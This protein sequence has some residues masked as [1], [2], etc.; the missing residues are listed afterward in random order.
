M[1]LTS[2]ATAGTSSGRLMDE[3]ANKQ[4]VLGTVS[5]GKHRMNHK[6]LV[7]NC[8]DVGMAH[9][10]DRAAF[11][12]LENRAISSASVMVP[13]PW[14]ME[15]ASYLRGRRDLDIGIHLTLT[16][17]SK[18]YKWG[19]ITAKERVPSLL[20]PNGFFWPEASLVIRHVDAEQVRLEIRQQIEL[21][22]RVGIEPTHVDSHMWTLLRSPALVDVYLSVAE[23]YHLPPRVL[24]NQHS[25][26]LKNGIRLDML[27]FVRNIGIQQDVQPARWADFYQQVIDRLEPGI[28]ELI[29]HLGFDDAELRALTVGRPGW[30]APWRQ[31]DFDVITSP[32]FNEL[33]QRNNVTRIG[34][35]EVREHC[36]AMTSTIAS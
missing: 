30:D 36:S 19:P 27:P 22:M 20:D 21:A 35:R 2:P 25:S 31:R 5:R 11:H 34:W 29:V 26:L 10:I 6:L 7:I 32:E 23:E 33:L 17:Q 14:F 3:L 28:T 8:D 15:V 18:V 9:S 1:T 16:S 24:P 12:A 13:C 4:V